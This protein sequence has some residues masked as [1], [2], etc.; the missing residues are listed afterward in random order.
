MKVDP[1]LYDFA[2]PRQ[3]EF[4]DAIAVHGNAAAANRALGLATDVVGRAMR[5]LNP[6]LHEMEQAA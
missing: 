5:A 2:T 1:A 3:R 6:D 4:L